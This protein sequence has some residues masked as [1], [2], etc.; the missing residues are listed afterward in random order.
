MG[1]R[2]IGILYG[3]EAP[4]L[5]ATEDNDEPL[6]DLISNWEK[7]KKLP[8]VREGLRIRLESEGGKDLLGVWVAIGGGG[9]DN[10]T[11]FLDDCVPLSQVADLYRKDILKA[12]KLWNRFAKHVQKHEGITLPEPTLWLTPCETA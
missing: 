9:E 6:Y 7:A 12:A 11:C 3:C 4:K 1:Q 2:S 10:T 5:P 8:L